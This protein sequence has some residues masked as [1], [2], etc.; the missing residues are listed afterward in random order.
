MGIGEEFVA[1]YR[2]EFDF[3]DH[4][5]RL[6]AQQL[7]RRTQASGLRAMVTSRAK[8]PERL[9]EK[10]RKR[11]PGGGYD[12]IEHIY[13]DIVDLA[14]VRVALYFPHERQE[15]EK[16]IR[17]QFV[18]LEPP[19]EF[20]ASTSPTYAKRFSGYWASHYRVKLREDSLV[21]VQKR[22]ADARIEIQV[23][24]VLMHA[25]AE[26]EHDLV[27][28][29]LQGRL[30]EDEY[31]IL[32]EL[33]GLVLAGE[34]ALERL[35]RAAEV[36]AGRHGSRFSNHYDLA[37]FLFEATR[38]ILG[39]SPG[40]AALGR[41][42]LLFEFLQEVGLDRPEALSPFITR[43][44]GDFDRRSV[45]EQIVDQVLSADASRYE[46]YAA[47]KSVHE[48]IYGDLDVAP[49]RGDDVDQVVG[50]FLSLWIKFELFIQELGRLLGAR[51]EEFVPTGKRL[52]G[53]RVFDD[54]LIF[55]ID[56]L[57]RLRN[58][59]VHGV[60]MPDSSY[61]N[62][63]ADKLRAIFD[64]LRKSRSPEVRAAVE[65]TETQS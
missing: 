34:I 24:S 36:R 42:R 50:E 29:P 5:S 59:L 22:F 52:A 49:K 53:F 9:L 41:V 48:Q 18:L 61:L 2:R 14:G 23:A 38:P 40:E 58:R 15:V 62:A 32:D 43:L 25:W 33:N 26:V 63:A 12:S 27:Y 64:N 47:L 57:R 4:A 45:A 1:Q 46:K 10:I 7:E 56:A 55:E 65:R 54:D 28:K 30:S 8:Q 11:Q 21:D 16:V 60:E 35:Q 44:H 19:K 51:G 39:S 6:V 31:A 17:A 3:F 37:A 13:A 20:P